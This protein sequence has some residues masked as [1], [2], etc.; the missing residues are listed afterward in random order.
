M[1]DTRTKY[2]ILFI[3]VAKKLSY[4]IYNINTFVIFIVIG[5]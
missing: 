3:K 5:N 4:I 2:N 1:L